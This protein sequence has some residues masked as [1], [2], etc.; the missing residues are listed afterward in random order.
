[1]SAAYGWLPRE[2]NDQRKDVELDCNKGFLG[3]FEATFDGEMEVIA[4]LMEYT[5]DNHIPGDLTIHSDAHGPMSRIGH[6][7]TGSGQDRGFRVVEA[8]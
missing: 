7:G 8:V 3:E 6:T 5:I 1:V 4:D 2:Y